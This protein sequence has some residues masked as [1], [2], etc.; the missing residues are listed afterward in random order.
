[1]NRLVKANAVSL[2]RERHATISAASQ[3]VGSSSI[4]VEATIIES[5]NARIAELENLL[6]DARHA[7]DGKEA[8]AYERGIKEGRQKASEAFQRDDETQLGYLKR[9]IQDTAS[10]CDATLDALPA[11]S[12]DL[13]EAALSR[14]IDEPGRYGE[15]IA[16]VVD[17]Q[18]R[19]LLAD[20]VLSV[21]IS[22]KDF[23]SPER[24]DELLSHIRSRHGLTIDVRTTAE[25]G[26]CTF[27][28]SLGRMEADLRTQRQRLA[29]IFAE[30]RNEN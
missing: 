20:S 23:P 5:L 26:S 11:L 2:T 10:R 13:A 8:A 6:T 16:Q 24:V 17:R 25:A 28:L 15:I 30:L 18:M 12:I 19:H 1:M 29:A 4:A 9:A 27:Q 3:A 7:S 21:D 14:V 22:A